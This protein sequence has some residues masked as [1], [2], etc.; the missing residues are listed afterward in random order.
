MEKVMNS[1]FKVNKDRQLSE[2]MDHGDEYY[3]TADIVQ[4]IE[5]N[6]IK[7]KV[8]DD[9]EASPVLA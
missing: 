8:I 4:V 9:K 3:H 5:E 1:P 7:L 6:S 2:G